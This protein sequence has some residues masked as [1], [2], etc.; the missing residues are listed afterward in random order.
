MWNVVRRM[1]AREGMASG[2]SQIEL[3]T[4]EKNHAATSTRKNKRSLYI[5]RINYHCKSY[6]IQL[7]TLRVQYVEMDPHERP[8]N[9]HENLRT[10]RQA[11]GQRDA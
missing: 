1:R 2:K 4:H 9:T 8:R 3:W 10:P 11:E 7:C 5:L 6:G